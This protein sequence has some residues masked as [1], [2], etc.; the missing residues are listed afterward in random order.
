VSE[1]AGKVVCLVAAAGRGLRFGREVPKSFYP[2][3]GRTLMARSLGSLG[4]WGSISRFIVMVP[5]GWEEK[6][7]ADISGNVPGLSVTV[8]AGGETRQESVAKGLKTVEDAE[9]V[10]VH[11]ACR[12]LVSVPLVERVVTAAVRYGAAVPVLQVTDTLGR[13]RDEALEGIVPRERVVG[14]QTPQAFK[15]EVLRRAFEAADDTKLR[16]TDESSLVLAAGYPVRV[17]EGE[18]WN[19]KVTVKDDLEIIASFLEGKRIDLPGKGS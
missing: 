11:D 10:V 15:L 4:A 1:K 2:V 18:R 3:A 6:A 14:I 8:L 17:V 7:E 5:E 16:S 12:P 9:L 13:L 19:I